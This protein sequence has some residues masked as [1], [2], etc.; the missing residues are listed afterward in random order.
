MS[1]KGA[2]MNRKGAFMSRKGAFMSRK[3]AFMNRKGAFWYKCGK[4][5]TKPLGSLKSRIP[6]RTFYSGVERK[7][8]GFWQC[9]TARRCGQ[10]ASGQYVLT[11]TATDAAP[12]WLCL[13]SLLNKA[14]SP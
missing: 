1:R 13:Y 12:G 4:S 7:T 3:G 10:A 2:F 9:D 6:M 14:H 11:L 5:L 8:P